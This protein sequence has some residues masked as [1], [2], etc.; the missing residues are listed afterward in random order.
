MANLDEIKNDLEDTLDYSKMLSTSKR[1]AYLE[2]AMVTWIAL[3]HI[4]EPKIR[5]PLKREGYLE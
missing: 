4:Y 5:K 1:N 2:A 3:R